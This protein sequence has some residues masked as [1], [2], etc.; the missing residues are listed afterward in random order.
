MVDQKMVYLGSTN[1]G[2]K[3]LNMHDHE[4]NLRVNSPTLGRE[5][6]TQFEQETKSFVR[7]ETE[8]IVKTVYKTRDVQQWTGNR[9]NRRQITVKQP[10]TEEAGRRLQEKLSIELR[11][12]MRF[13]HLK[14]HPSQWIVVW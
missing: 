2:E 12:L 11:F 14:W 7:T 10:Y 13:P 5:V 6:F 4:I 9:R 3:S 8:T 1:L